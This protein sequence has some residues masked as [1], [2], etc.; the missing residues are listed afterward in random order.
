[1]QTQVKYNVIVKKKKN[2]QYNAYTT[3]DQSL[4]LKVTSR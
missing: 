2:V 4:W 3:T 1:M